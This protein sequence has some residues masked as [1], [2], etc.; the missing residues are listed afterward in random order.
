MTEGD[1]PCSLTTLMRARQHPWITSGTGK[2][3]FVEALA[4]AAIEN[5]M[6]VAWFTLETLTT[7][8]GKAKVDGTIARA[9]SKICGCDLI[10]IDLCRTRDYDDKSWR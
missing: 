9:I 4:H 8:V 5:D 7:A 10:V 3:H 2:S 1:Q 6:R